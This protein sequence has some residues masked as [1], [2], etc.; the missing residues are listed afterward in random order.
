[1]HFLFIGPQ[2]KKLCQGHE[3]HKDGEVRKLVQGQ[4]AQSRG[5]HTRQ[6]SKGGLSEC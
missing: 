1:M 5:K 6:S 4:P 2:P 3:C